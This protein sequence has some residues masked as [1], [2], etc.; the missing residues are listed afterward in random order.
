LKTYK[1]TSTAWENAYNQLRSDFANLAADADA[2]L[3]AI[4]DSV[5]RDLRASRMKTF[6]NVSIPVV[7]ILAAWGF[8]N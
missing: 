4:E 7:I 5:N 8:T 6:W 2:N 3:Q 1:Q